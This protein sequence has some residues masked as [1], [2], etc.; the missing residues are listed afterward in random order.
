MICNLVFAY[1]PSCESRLRIPDDTYNGDVLRC[2]QCGYLMKI[3]DNNTSAYR[4]P[5]KFVSAGGSMISKPGT[6]EIVK[7]QPIFAQLD[8]PVD[9]DRTIR[10]AT[11]LLL[12]QDICVRR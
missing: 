7:T 10:R 4:P 5:R 12:N 1:C 11:A 8:R 3:R 2:S 9:T 6:A